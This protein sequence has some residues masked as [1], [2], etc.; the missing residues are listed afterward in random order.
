MTTRLLF[1]VSAAVEAQTGIAMLIAPAHV[2]GLLLGDGLSQTGTAVTRVL[3]IGL[4]SLGVSAWENARQ[5]VKPAA[6]IGICIYNIGAA[7]LLGMCGTIGEMSGVML[8]PAVGL[9]GL[10]G[11]TMLWVILGPS[12]KPS[13]D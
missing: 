2:I 5:Q 6:R 4:L 3:G 13:V 12:R 7:A 9:H 11:A 8:W 1:N 10:I